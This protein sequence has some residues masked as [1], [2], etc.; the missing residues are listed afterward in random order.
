M[1]GSG[2]D[3]F[4]GASRDDDDDEDEVMGKQKS[5]CLLLLLLLAG[6]KPDRVYVKIMATAAPE[7][8]S[9][10]TLNQRVRCVDDFA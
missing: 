8:T 10:A 3:Y 7:G 1:P 9:K 6:S 2:G 5:H 4:D